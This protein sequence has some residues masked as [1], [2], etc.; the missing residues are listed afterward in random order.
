MLAAVRNL[1]GVPSIE[2]LTCLEQSVPTAVRKLRVPPRSNWNTGRTR[3]PQG[4]KHRSPPNLDYRTF[5]P[6]HRFIHWNL[7]DSRAI[8]TLSPRVV[9]IYAANRVSILHA[10][11][12]KKCVFR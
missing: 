1:N 2:N 12:K 11:L 5:I 6:L 10:I 9:D 8:R 4:P 3:K 7:A